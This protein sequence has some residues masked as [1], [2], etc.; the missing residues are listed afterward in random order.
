MSGGVMSVLV[1][2]A[3]FIVGESVFPRLL[4]LLWRRLRGHLGMPAH[5]SESVP[6]TQ[7][8]KLGQSAPHRTVG[9]AEPVESS[10]PVENPSSTPP[11][12][13]VSTSRT[14]SA[15]QEPRTPADVD[16]EPSP[17]AEQLWFE[18]RLLPHGFI[19]DLEHDAAY[20]EKL[21][22]AAKLGHVLSMMKL[23]D[24]AVRRGA[25]V[26]AYYW[27]SLADLRGATGLEM[28]LRNMRFDW[29][30]RGYPEQRGN[31]Y[32][33]FSEQQGDFARAL[34]R[35]RDAVNPDESRARMRELSESG[36]VEAQLFLEK[37]NAA[38]GRRSTVV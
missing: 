5:T 22:A 6:D 12:S 10:S 20:L 29:R 36:C 1:L 17:T 25:I 2:I 30:A 32:T 15:V 21:C 7:E 19:P 24:Y 26:E 3:A 37:E 27:M 16:A 23:S 38:A 18:A 11:P 13:P 33:G 8:A 31:V 14:R 35:I 4:S 34:L 9:G 28:T